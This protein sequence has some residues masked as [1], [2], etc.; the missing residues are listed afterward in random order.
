MSVGSGN[1]VINS[2]DIQ[3]YFNCNSIFD[4]FL[5]LI[6]ITKSLINFFINLQDLVI[7]DFIINLVNL[8]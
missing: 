4:L 3:N 2:K 8:I 5:N 6:I 1:I 7:I